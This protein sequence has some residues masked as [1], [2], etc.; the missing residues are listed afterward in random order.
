MAVSSGSDT[1]TPVY[2]LLLQ[3]Q[4]K[5]VLHTSAR[6]CEVAVQRPGDKEASYITTLR[7]EQLQSQQPPLWQMTVEL[8]VMTLLVLGSQPHVLLWAMVYK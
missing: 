4:Q 6:M 5:L 1:P 3:A 8:Q 7:G 2:H